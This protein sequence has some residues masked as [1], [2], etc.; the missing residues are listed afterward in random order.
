MTTSLKLLISV[1]A[2]AAAFLSLASCSGDNEPAQQDP[3][4]KA[5][6]NFIR[7]GNKLFEENS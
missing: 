4:T 1:I 5:E 7:N 6:R 3:S 2:T